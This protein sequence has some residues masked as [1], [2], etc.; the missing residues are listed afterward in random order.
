MK[1]L[2]NGLK[3]ELDGRI[4][5]DAPMAGLAV[6]LRFLDG[7]DPDTCIEQCRREGLR[8]HP[9]AHYYLGEPLPFTRMGFAQ[10]QETALAVA[11]ATLTRALR[12][13]TDM[14]R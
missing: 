7:Q 4:A 3:Q 14:E 6:W 8:L 13:Q 2:V 1:F 9:P 12:P 11:L 5:V 10:A